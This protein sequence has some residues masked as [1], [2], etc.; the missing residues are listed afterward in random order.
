MTGI[1]PASP[2]PPLLK[3][4]TTPTI[5]HER[6][7]ELSY[8]YTLSMS[9]SISILIIKF[10]FQGVLTLEGKGAARQEPSSTTIEAPP[11]L[12]ITDAS[13]FAI[14]LIFGLRPTR[15]FQDNRIAFNIHFIE[16]AKVICKTVAFS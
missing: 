15:H 2:A 5:S 8:I 3:V 16:Q 7:H 13:S 1:E 14:S 6:R 4:S 10:Q 9:R 11:P 12:Y